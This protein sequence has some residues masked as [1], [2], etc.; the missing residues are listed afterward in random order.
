MLRDVDRLT[1]QAAAKDRPAKHEA[2]W[3]RSRAP[4]CRRSSGVR[5]VQLSRPRWHQ[6][7]IG[8]GY[9]VGQTAGETRRAVDDEQVQACGAQRNPRLGERPP[10]LHANR[11]TRHHSPL[12][13]GRSRVKGQESTY[14]NRAARCLEAHPATQASSPYRGRPPG[15]KNVVRTRLLH[16]SH[17]M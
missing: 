8:N 15:F 2:V 10:T 3:P 14:R 16:I 9:C 6:H 12:L 4:H 7:Q 13:G 17:R 5:Q 11:S 1:G